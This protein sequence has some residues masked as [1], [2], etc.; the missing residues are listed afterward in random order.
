MNLSM[1]VT[2]LASAMRTFK[3][4]GGISGIQNLLGENLSKIN[5]AKKLF[6][7]T[8]MIADIYSADKT[9]L[10]TPLSQVKDFEKFNKQLLTSRQAVMTLNKEFGSLGPAIQGALANGQKGFA[11]L[12]IGINS[13]KAALIEL[14]PMLIIGAA[15]AAIDAVQQ[16]IDNK[17]AAEKKAM[18]DS[19]AQAKETHE[20]VSK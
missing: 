2:Q 7:K 5:P 1:T 14:A 17:I 11:T 20:S 18:E 13:V 8:N 9:L 4:L 12:L 19:T 15:I 6:A 10:S 16:D 3:A